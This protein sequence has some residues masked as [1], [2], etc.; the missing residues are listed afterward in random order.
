MPLIGSTSDGA[1]LAAGNTSAAPF[2][3]KVSLRLVMPAA[4]YADPSSSARRMWSSSAVAGRVVNRMMHSP[5]PASI[6]LPDAALTPH[7]ATT[8]GGLGSVTKALGDPA[9]GV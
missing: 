4:A 6:G 5:S 7:G 3:T 2:C 9:R 1:T 8:G